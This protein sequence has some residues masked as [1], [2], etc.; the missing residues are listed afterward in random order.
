VQHDPDPAT[1]GISRSRFLGLMAAGGVLGY[2]GVLIGGRSVGGWRE[3]T[4][5]APTPKFD[6]DAYR[7][8]IDGL[9]QRPLTLTYDDLRALPAVDQVSDFHCVEGWTVPD[10]R[11]RGVRLQQLIDQARPTADARYI[12]FHSMGGI[13]RD[14]LSIQQAGL[15][16]A[17]IAYDMDG[18]PLPQDR[19]LPLRVVMPRMFG[20]KGAKWLRRI[21]FRDDQDIGY[22][23][24]RGWRVDAWVKV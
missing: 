16:D 7:L 2:A 14:S 24:Q 6:R 12:T 21:E 18:Q 5:E 3:N 10:V 19:G 23:E 20:Y 8:T 15:P 9:V 1:R 4:V 13:Y 17:L 22:W 11:W